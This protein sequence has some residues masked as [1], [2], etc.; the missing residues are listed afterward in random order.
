MPPP[1]P[2]RHIDGNS[3]RQVSRASSSL[4]RIIKSLAHHQVSRASSNRPRE[5]RGRFGPE[6]KVTH[7]S[8]LFTAANSK[9]SCS[10]RR[11]SRASRNQTFAMHEVQDHAAG[12][13]K[14]RSI[15]CVALTASIAIS[16]RHR[17]SAHR[18][19]MIIE[20]ALSVK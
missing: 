14:T 1:R 7:A 18:T 10:R 3:R 13:S 11:L 9:A 2:A 16:D 4:S 19:S 6:S 17:K 5:S 20:V 15:P 8:M 12:E